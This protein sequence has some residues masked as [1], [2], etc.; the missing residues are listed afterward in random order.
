M[1]IE[2]VTILWNILSVT[3]T[4]VENLEFRKE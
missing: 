1:Y 2:S 4:E 3:K